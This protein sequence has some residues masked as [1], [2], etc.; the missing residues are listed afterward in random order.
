MAYHNTFKLCILLPQLNHEVQ[1][2]NYTPHPSPLT[3]ELHT[4]LLQNLAELFWEGN[5]EK[6]RIN[7]NKSSTTN[8]FAKVINTYDGIKQVI[9]HETRRDFNEEGVPQGDPTKPHITGI[10]MQVKF[11]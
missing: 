2:S 1:G 5:K 10:I 8:L 11:L 7:Q 6:G 4:K 3:L 9:I